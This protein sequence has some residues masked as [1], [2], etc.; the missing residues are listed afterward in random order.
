MCAC[1]CIA[2]FCSDAKMGRLKL[3]CQNFGAILFLTK[4]KLKWSIIQILI[5]YLSFNRFT[6]AQS[7][8]FEHHKHI[9]DKSSIGNQRILG[10]AA[11]VNHQHGMIDF[12]FSFYILLFNFNLYTYTYNLKICLYLVLTT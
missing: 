1:V 10:D 3:K 5:I 7:F 6:T 12:L 9:L 8:D 4:I 2:V 11:T